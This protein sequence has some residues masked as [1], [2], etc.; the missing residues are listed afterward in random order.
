MTLLSI[1]AMAQED[2]TVD[3]SYIPC[4]STIVIHLVNNTDNQMRI[5]NNFGGGTSGS[6]IPFHLKDK[7]GKEISMYEAVFYEGVDYQRIVDINSHSTKTIKYPLKFL[8]PSS[9]NVSEIYSVDANYFIRYSIPE[10]NISAYLDKVLSIK[11][12]LDTIIY[13]DENKQFIIGQSIKAMTQADI[14][15]DAF[16]L[17]CDSTIVIHLGNNTDKLI[18]IRNDYGGTSSGSIIELHLKD[19]ANKEISM[20]QAVFYEGVDYQHFV[21]INPHS[22]K[23]I[24]YPLKFFCPSSRSVSEIYSVDASCFID[25]KIQELEKIGSLHKILSIK[26]KQDL[27]IY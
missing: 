22:T 7:A 16:Y 24:K 12:K 5:F 27:M 18:R 15:V 3:A 26:T 23:T 11:T 20:Y 1:R 2:I 4:D 17:P 21:D 9:R 6:M 13:R 25:Y 8:C 19:K 14:T 10:K